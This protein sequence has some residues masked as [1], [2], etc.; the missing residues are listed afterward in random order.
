MRAPS[1]GKRFYRGGL[2]SA[3]LLRSAAAQLEGLAQ[4]LHVYSELLASG[5]HFLTPVDF[6]GV[7]VPLAEVRKVHAAR[8][9]RTW[10]V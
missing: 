2:A 4:A 1:Q 6:L 3:R 9:T 7:V 8:R 5:A 10:C